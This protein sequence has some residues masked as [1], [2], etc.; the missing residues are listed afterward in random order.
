MRKKPETILALD[1]GLREFGY[2]VLTG[3][4]L[5]TSGVVNLRELPAARRLAAARA[6]VRRWAGAHR[7]TAIVVEKTYPH[8]LPW[9]ARLHRLTLGVRHIARHRHAEFADYAP[10]TVRKSLVGNGWANKPEVAVAVAHRFPQLRVHLTQD[11]RWK[12]RYWQNMFDAVALAI[13]HQRSQHPP[14]RGR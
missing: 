12:E 8:P 9:F 13:H 10:Q 6:H 4:R 3:R 1:P 2:A 11:R 14:S 5:A 7:P